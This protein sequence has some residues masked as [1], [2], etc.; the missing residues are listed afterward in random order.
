[1]NEEI[2]EIV[3]IGTNSDIVFIYRKSWHGQKLPDVRVS[4]NRKELLTVIKKTCKN[5]PLT[6]ENLHSLYPNYH[7]SVFINQEQQ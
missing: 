4:I 6:Q 1:M 2:K 3:L 7:R 5:F